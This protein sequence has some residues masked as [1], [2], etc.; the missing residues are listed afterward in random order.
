M[1]RFDKNGSQALDDAIFSNAS[2]PIARMRAQNHALSGEKHMAGTHFY[3][4]TAITLPAACG[5]LAPGASPMAQK[6]R[7]PPV[8]DARLPLIGNV[9]VNGNL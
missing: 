1:R 2:T 5:A 8:V 4:A 9:P 7:C 3:T 6:N